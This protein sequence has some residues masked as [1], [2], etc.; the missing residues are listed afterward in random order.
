LA[1]NVLMVSANE[2]SRAKIAA[3]F[4]R[5]TSQTRDPARSGRQLGVR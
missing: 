4:L 1:F 2:V 3:C 5:T